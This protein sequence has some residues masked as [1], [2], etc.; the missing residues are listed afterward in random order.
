LYCHSRNLAVA[1]HSI[2]DCP[3]SFERFV[4][5]ATSLLLFDGYRGS[6]IHLH[7]RSRSRCNDSH[8]TDRYSQA[9]QGQGP[10]WSRARRPLL[11]AQGEEEPRRYTL[12]DTKISN[13]TSPTCMIS[14]RLSRGRECL[15]QGRDEQRGVREEALRRVPVSYQAD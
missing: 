9:V 1:Y 15:H 3:L 14:D 11:L 10:V 13:R 7:L 4:Y 2:I 12:R 5:L 8:A 6:S